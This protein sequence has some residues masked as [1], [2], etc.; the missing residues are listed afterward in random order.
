[1]VHGKPAKKSK[2]YNNYS[3]NNDNNSNYSNNNNKSVGVPSHF[4]TDAYIIDDLD[5]KLLELILKGYE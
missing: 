3:N 4:N 5:Q 1:M 2:V